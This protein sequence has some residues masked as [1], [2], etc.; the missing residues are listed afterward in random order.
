MADDLAKL[1]YTIHLSRRALGIIRQNIALALASKP[2]ALALIFPG[3]LTLWL[4]VLADMGASLLVT[5]NGMRLVGEQQD[6]FNHE[7]HEK[8]EINA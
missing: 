2:L 1:P 4:A 5:L 6:G 7:K 3:W 8:V